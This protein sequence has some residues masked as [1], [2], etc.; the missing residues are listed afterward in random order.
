ML[1]FRVPQDARVTVLAGGVQG[2]RVTVAQLARLVR[3]ESA[4]GHPLF[5][6]LRTGFWLQVDVDTVR[7]LDQQYVP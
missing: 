4:L 1:T 7:S 5:E 2:T 3:D 6:P